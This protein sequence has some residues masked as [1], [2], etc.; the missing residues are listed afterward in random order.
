L[1]PIFHIYRINF[2]DPAKRG[3]GVGTIFQHHSR[4]S[5]LSHKSMPIRA[6]KPLE[7]NLIEATI[8][9]DPGQEII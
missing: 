1:I 2:V 5:S 7:I 6:E 4:P 3:K 8:S 9:F